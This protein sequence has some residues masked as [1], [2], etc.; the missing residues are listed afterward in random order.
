MDPSRANY[1]YEQGARQVTPVGLYTK[2][3]TAE[4]VCDMLGNVFEWCADWYGSYKEE[5]QENPKGHRGGRFRVLRGG[6]WV[7]SPQS[8]RVSYRNWYVPTNRNVVVG[9]RCAG[10]LRCVPHI[11]T[12]RRNAPASAAPASGPSTGTGA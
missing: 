1:Y 3:N 9:F 6:T 7:N 8:V 5:D 12:A 11:P 10:K 2:G 4:G